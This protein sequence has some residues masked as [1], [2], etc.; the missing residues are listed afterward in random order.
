MLYLGN[1]KKH[2]QALLT[3]LAPSKQDRD[4]MG[5][6]HLHLTIL[7]YAVLNNHVRML[8]KAANQVF[9]M[10][11]LPGIITEK[12]ES[13]KKLRKLISLNGAE[14]RTWD[15]IAPVILSTY[16]CAAAWCY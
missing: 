2:T 5:S 12:T 4:R 15:M 9:E 8:T 14:M 6:S 3:M 10:Q 7:Y 1:Q 13:E 16:A 11:R